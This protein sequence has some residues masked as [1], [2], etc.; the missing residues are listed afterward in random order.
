[1]TATASDP[2]RADP[3]RPSP[4]RVGLEI[5]RRF[6][7]GWAIWRAGYA[8][9]MKSGLLKRRFPMLNL[10][11]VRF[12]SL[13]RP[14]TPVT[15]DAYRAFREQSTARF[16]FEHGRPP[17][18]DRLR[19][20]A[21][22][23]GGERALSVAE[24]FARGRFLYYSRHVHD[25]GQPVD[26]LLNPWTGGRHAAEIHW[27]D[28]P[29]FSKERGDIKDV[30]EPSRFAAAFWLVRAFA[31]TGDNRFAEAFWTLFESWRRQNS[32]NRGPNWKCGQEIAL[33]TLAWCFALYGLWAAEA[34]TPQRV[35]DLVTLIAVQADRIAGNIGFAVSQ[36]NNHALSEAVG[37]LTVGLLFPEL[38]NAGRWERIGRATL[39]QEIPRQVYEDGSFVQ[40]SMNYH[41]VM[42][43][44]LLWAIRL[45]DLNDRPLSN[46]CRERLARAGRFLREMLDD[47][48]GRTP[49]YGPNDGALVL[50]LTSCDYADYRPTV[51]AAHALTTGRPVLPPGPWDELTLWLVGEKALSAEPERLAPTSQRFDSGGYYTIRGPRTWAMIRCHGYRDRPAHVDPLHVDLWYRGLNV[52]GDSGTYK[53]YAADRPAL[54]RYF[55]DIAAHNTIE[56][57]GRGPLDLVSRFLWLPWPEAECLRHE[58]AYWEGESYAYRRSPWQVVH[59]RAVELIGEREWR[60]LDEVS[61]TGRHRLTLR[62]HL[63]EAAWQMDEDSS[64][65]RLS[66]PEGAV[67]VSV[68]GPAGLAVRLRRGE[69]DETAAAGWKSEYYAE[70]SPRPTLE[71]DGVFELPVRL[72][73]IV[74]LGESG[75]P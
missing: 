14:G 64:P 46:L 35:Q 18:P 50:P 30:W 11:D 41:R 57:D 33:R 31:L 73:T 17:S 43:H 29:T 34:T 13:V 19:A 8:I 61:G 45:A 58:P 25:L 12:E 55:K 52:F 63:L 4:I 37:L 49:N 9:R 40:H 38:T 20:V 67:V 75:G 10:A 1:M 54:E 27:C 59:R 62:W 48:S 74:K 23:A 39:E 44:D 65:A 68:A 51:Q 22:P 6:G 2:G 42:M 7:P 3:A 72:T 32:P 28:Y 21:T 24:D 5:I 53:Y 56:V 70:L 66:W 15:P 26:W 47:D 69:A 60:I 16:F 36:K 71:A